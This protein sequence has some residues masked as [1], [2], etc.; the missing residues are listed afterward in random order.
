MVFIQHK[1][2]SEG[3]KGYR[4]ILRY[5]CEETAKRFNVLLVDF[6]YSD[7]AIFP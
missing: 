4:Q 3:E 5:R 6:R 7:Y 2:G 1:I